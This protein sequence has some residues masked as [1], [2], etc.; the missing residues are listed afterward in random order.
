MGIG[1]MIAGPFA[2]RILK[3][4]G[5]KI[6]IVIGSIITGIGTYMQSFITID[7][8]FLDF[9]PS[10]LL[11]GIGTQLLFMGS[12]YICFS[13]LKTKQVPNASAMYN[14]TMR[15]TA[16]ISIAVSGNYFIIF[17]KQF[18]S[19]MSDYNN[20]EILALNSI[21]NINI[22]N[23]FLENLILLYEKESFVMAFNKISF[24]CIW[25]SAIPL[26]L[27]LILKNKKYTI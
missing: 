15:L 4:Y 8:I 9:L 25:T 18:Y 17:K 12:Q 23:K 2:G 27:L 19:F 24:I 3:V 10:Q 13:E 21:E 1:M 11:K 26:L 20:T 5:A 7:F 6:I 16:A 22:N 14:L